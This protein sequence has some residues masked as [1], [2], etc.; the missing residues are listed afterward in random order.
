VPDSETEQYETE[1]PERRS[2][3]VS[4]V[5]A[6]FGLIFF[7]GIGLAGGAAYRLM[8]NG[9][10]DAQL[11]DRIQPSNSQPTNPAPQIAAAPPPMQ[12]AAATPAPLTPA[13]P[14]DNGP[15]FTAP[16]LADI[17]PT[18]PPSV[19]PPPAPAIAATVVPA[20]PDPSPATADNIKP[21]RPSTPRTVA[22]IPQKKPQV[23][24]KPHGVAK[25]L[26]REAPAQAVALHAPPTGPGNS[27]GPYRVQFG[28]FANEENARRVQWAVEATGVKVEVTQAPGAGGRVL[29]YLRSPAYYD[30]AAAL[31]AAQTVQS[32]V[33]GFVNA[34]PIEYAVLGD[35]ATAEQQAQAR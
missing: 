16:K 3:V 27:S 28:A 6:V 5:Y 29:Y 25:T 12:T 20:S 14:S 11:S 1:L 17:N 22:A 15:A 32:R 13:S 24:A 2:A 4:T 30:Y 9:A 19:P 23:A 7:F 26:T 34:I 8:D 33:Q 21:A 35:R 10:A 31:S 18:A